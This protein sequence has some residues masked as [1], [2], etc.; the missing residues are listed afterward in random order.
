[1]PTLVS[2]VEFAQLAGVSQRRVSKWISSGDLAGDALVLEGRR[3]RIDVA[4]ARRQLGA[5]ITVDQRLVPRARRRPPGSAELPRDARGETLNDIAKEKLDALKLA[6]EK[7]RADAAANAGRFV[8]ADGVKIELGRT[9]G[10]LI[11]SFEGAL[12]ELAEAVAA[13]GGIS[14]RDALHALR[15]HGGASAPA[16]QAPRAAPLSPCPTWSRPA[17]DPRCELGAPGPRGACRR[18]QAAGTET[19]FVDRLKDKGYEPKRTETAR[20]FKG[21]ALKVNDEPGAAW[22]V[23]WRPAF[24]TGLTPQYIKTVMAREAV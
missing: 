8:E 22:E 1:M 14:E 11:S 2:K 15:A 17:H 12:P 13:R 23:R 16:W 10:R 20:G 24:L 19:A 9:A 5:R 4:A 18:P 21:I 3:E 6:N 7:A